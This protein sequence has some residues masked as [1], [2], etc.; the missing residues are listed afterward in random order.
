MKKS[1]IALV[2]APTVAL[3]TQSVLYAMVTPSCS[4]QMRLNIHLAAA[5]A[6]LVVVVLA[7]M[8]YGQSSVYRREPQSPDHDGAQPPVPGRFFGD[9]AAAVA[10]LSALVILAMWFGVWVLSPCA[11]I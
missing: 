5:V 4:A 3:A 6:L 10:A 11:I 7:V 2:F 1:W 8:A 9:V